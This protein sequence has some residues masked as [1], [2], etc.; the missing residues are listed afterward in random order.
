MTVC[1]PKILFLFLLCFANHSFSQET[2]KIAKKKIFTYDVN[3]LAMGLGPFN[4]RVTSTNSPVDQFVLENFNGG[5]F[6]MNLL[7]FRPLLKNVIGLHF[8]LGLTQAGSKDTYI[9][10]NFY[11]MVPGYTVTY[12]DPKEHDGLG[13]VWVSLT[14]ATFD[15]GIVGKINIGQ[16][17][18]LPFVSYTKVAGRNSLSVDANL[19]N[20]NTGETFARYYSWEEKISPSYKFGLEAKFNFYDAPCLGVRGIYSRFITNG[21]SSYKDRFSDG[22][23]FSSMV[24]ANSFTSE[25]LCFQVFVGF[26]IGGN[27]DEGIIPA[28]KFHTTYER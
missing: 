11:T 7:E 5:C 10:D 28:M 12:D 27:Q 6:G 2:P 19:T 20:Q 8:G 9:R 3:V 4:T 21:E 24:H 15:M 17:S 13:P 14:A 16:V 25:F 22:S 1:N 23:T 18:I 26:T